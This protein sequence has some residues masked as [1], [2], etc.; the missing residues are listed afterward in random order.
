[1]TYLEMINAVLRR[2]REESVSTVNESDYSTL[3]GDFVNDAVR[4]VE[5]AW[6]WQVLR[7][8]LTVNTVAGTDT[9]TLTG[10]SSR[11]EIQEVHNL[12]ENVQVRKESLWQLRRNNLADTAPDGSPMY[13]SV[14]GMDSSNQLKVQLWPTPDSVEAIKFYLINRSDNLVEDSDSISVPS[15]P[16]IL[17]AY[18]FALAERGETGGQS[19]SEQAAF[20]RQEL[21]NA[22]AL[23][24]GHSPEELIWD[25]V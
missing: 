9:Y 11:T 6:D 5:D 10:T 4:M 8:P 16:V 22:I 3:I 25:T 24:A 20:A 1:M 23:D 21:T 19:S 12:D 13:Y 14:A 2:L 18:A 7:T 17:Y 15:A